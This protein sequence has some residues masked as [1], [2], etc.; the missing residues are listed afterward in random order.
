MGLSNTF[1]VLPRCCT[2]IIELKRD[3]YFFPLSSIYI[4][5]NNF[6][7]MEAMCHAKLVWLD[8]ISTVPHTSYWTSG[9]EVSQRDGRC[10]ES[11]KPHIAK[12]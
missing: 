2:Q 10:H 8:V 12:E 11:A 3:G 9:P 7:R 6:R 1:V 5:V 4:F